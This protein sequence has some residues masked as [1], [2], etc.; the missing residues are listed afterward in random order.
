MS[1]VVETRGSRQCK[2]HHQKLIIKFGSIPEIMDR[3]PEEIAY[4]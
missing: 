3:L 1:K 4:M 2:S